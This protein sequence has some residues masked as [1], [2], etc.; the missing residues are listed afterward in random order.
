MLNEIIKLKQYKRSSVVVGGLILRI[1]VL[2]PFFAIFVVK[3][4]KRPHWLLTQRSCGN[5]FFPVQEKLF[6]TLCRHDKT[7]RC[8]GSSC[9]L[10]QIWVITNGFL[11]ERISRK[12]FTTEQ[13]KWQN[14]IAFVALVTV[15]RWLNY[16]KVCGYR[17]LWKLA[18]K[19]NFFAK[20]RLSFCQILN[21]PSKFCPNF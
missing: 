18:H 15:T 21:K 5:Y 10:P 3:A 9:G 16:F 13:L 6:F 19:H 14:R 2:A 17:Q 12:V 7:G 11:N 1:R 4:N 8:S 20:V